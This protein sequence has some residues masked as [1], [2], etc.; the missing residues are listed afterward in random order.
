[1]H[2]FA[3]GE[4]LWILR[5]CL[6][7]LF[8]LAL[9]SFELLSVFSVVVVRDVK[10]LSSTF[11]VV[12]MLFVETSFFVIHVTVVDVLFVGASVVV[13][14]SSSFGVAVS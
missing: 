10:S 7:D 8:G 12:E 5:C 1:M 9:S 2:L 13:I 6:L 3:V 14:F 11:D 4:P